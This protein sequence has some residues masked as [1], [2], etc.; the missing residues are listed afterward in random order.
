MKIENAKLKL[1]VWEA[2][3]ILICIFTI[4]GVGIIYYKMNPHVPILIGIISLLLYGRIKGLSF[5]IMERSLIEG[6]L[7]GLGAI[8][9]FFFI[10]MLISSWIASGTIPTI[11]FYGF[12][13]ISGTAFF[14]IV[15]LICSLIGLCIGSSLTTSATIGV[16][17][18]GMAAAFDF[19]LAITAGAVISGAF[20]GD[21]M[22]P[23]SDTSSFASETVGVPLFDHIKNMLWTTIPAFVITLLLFFFLS[24]DATSVKVEEMD[25]MLAALKAYTNISGW[26]LIPFLLVGVMA[27]RKISA[28]PT[29]AT[30]IFSAILIAFI[31]TK[32]ITAQAMAD[33]LYSGFVLNSGVVQLDSILSRGGIES[34][35]FSIS[36][37]LLALGMGGLLFELGIIPSILGSVQQKL[38]TTGRLVTA[39]VVTGVGVNVAIGEQ[40]LSILLPGKTFQGKYV[41]MGLQPKSLSR[42]LE[43]SGT[44]VN[45]LIPWGV[46]GVFLTQ[47][48]GVSTLEYMPFAFF[49]I[50]CPFLSLLS[51]YTKVGLHFNEK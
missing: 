28:I 3:I 14:A 41:E 24:P 40:Y 10:G 27:L 25:T 36:L 15:F 11:M 49:C 5:S 42:V 50:L 46:C 30:G 37:V 6:A 18:I 12:E 32:D 20:F 21:K 1:P 26:S 35:M 8:F 47:V 38:T 19:S 34:M 9:I 44:V 39:T 16:A 13:M 48:L 45:P 4:I 33:T 17:F 51:G 2:L 43:D 31:Q 29:L 23:L 7:S 22:S